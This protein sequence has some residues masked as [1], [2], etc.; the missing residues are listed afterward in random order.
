MGISFPNWNEPV[1]DAFEIIVG[2]A[3]ANEVA[4]ISPPIPNPLSIVGLSKEQS[5][6]IES[7]I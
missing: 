4:Q 6:A 1:D 2:P 5:V 3:I 7:V